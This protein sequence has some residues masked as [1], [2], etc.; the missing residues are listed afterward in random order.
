MVGMWNCWLNVKKMWLN[1]CN[2]QNRT[3]I[4]KNDLFLHHSS[5]KPSDT[6][7]Q[8]LAK[9]NDVSERMKKCLAYDCDMKLRK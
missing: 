3:K 8:W 6:E 5:A 9:R 4:Y 2:E 1:N 7:R